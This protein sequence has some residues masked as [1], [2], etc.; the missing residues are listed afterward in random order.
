MITSIAGQRE[1]FH[2]G[3]TRPAEWR[4]QQLEAMKALLA[5]NRDRFFATL[6]QDLRRI[7]SGCRPTGK[8]GPQP[9]SG[10]SGGWSTRAE[11]RDA[12]CSPC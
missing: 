4:R 12:R 9:C 5:D 1:Y 6:R 10:G 3:A 2:S 8:A 7:D 11:S